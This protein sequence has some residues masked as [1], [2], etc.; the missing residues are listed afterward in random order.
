MPTL[1]GKSTVKVPAGTQGGQKLRIKG[2]GIK[3]TGRGKGDMYLNITISVPKKIDK[4][5]K[6]LIEE[7]SEINSYEPRSGLW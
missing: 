6:E 3:G 4:R 7:F 2:A 1:S 5:S